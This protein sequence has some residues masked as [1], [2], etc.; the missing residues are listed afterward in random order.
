MNLLR[1]IL[2]PFAILY[3]FITSIRNYLFDTGVLKAYSFDLPVIAVGNLSVGG[4]GKTPQI[5]Y[6]IRL[7]SGKYKVATLSRGY[8][9]Q[10]EGFVLANDSSDAL[11]LGDEPFQFYQKFKNI[12]VAVDANR[13]NGIEQLLSNSNAPEV[14]LLDDAF[15]HR[16]VKAGFYIM[17]TSYGDLYCDDFMLPT[18]NLRESRSG[19][20]R[21]NVVIVTKC[22]SNLSLDAQNKIKKQLRLSSNQNLFFTF[23]EYDEVVYS[24][25]ETLKVEGIKSLNKI[26]LAGIAK[27][28]SFF[29]H[30]KQENDECLTFP[31]H[32]HFSESELLEIKK[33]ASNKII[34]TTEKDYVRLKGSILSGQLYFLPIKS[35]FLSDEDSFN[36]NILNYVGQST[37]NS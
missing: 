28:E 17:L 31:D 24:E 8:K 22:P 29:A 4:T 11:Q 26:L 13:K 6:L 37:R 20:Q 5:E 25:K 21:A 3:G 33:K 30:L 2:F 18:G 34:V 12:Q 1:K 23:I 10:S 27:P 16:K 7:L 35:T 14:I 32:H 19:V 15:Q 9:R 36:E